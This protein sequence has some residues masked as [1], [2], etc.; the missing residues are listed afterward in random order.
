[1][2]IK[3]EWNG[4]WPALCC[5]EWS[6]EVN[7]QDMTDKIPESLRKSSM[8]TCGSYQRWHFGDDWEVIWESYTD[9]LQ[10]EEWL[11]TITTD[12]NLQIDIFNEISE[13]DFRHGSC[14]GCI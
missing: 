8:N 7:G 2:G 1:M 5:G 3:A 6:L 4:K 10:C 11:D 12:K 9:G 14:G 13:S